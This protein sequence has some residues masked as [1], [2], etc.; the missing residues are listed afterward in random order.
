M[1][2]SSTAINPVWE[3]NRSSASERA[4]VELERLDLRRYDASVDSDRK[5]FRR[6]FPR[7]KTAP[8]SYL[9][10]SMVEAI[11]AIFGAMFHGRTY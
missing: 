8:Q 3:F 10:C 7:R 6:F 1:P 2:A 5:K 9:S 11:R 4:G